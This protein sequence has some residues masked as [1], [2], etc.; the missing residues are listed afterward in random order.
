MRGQIEQSNLA[1]IS[2]RRFHRSGKEV[3]D[4]IVQLDLVS[5]NGLCQQLSRERLGYGADFKNRVAVHRARLF[6]FADNDSSSVFVQNAGHNCDAITRLRGAF[7]E[8]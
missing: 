5:G 8:K 6:S 2:L 4:G 1:A 3:G 7:V